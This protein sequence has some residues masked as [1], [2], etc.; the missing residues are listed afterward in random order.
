MA[1]NDKKYIRKTGLGGAGLYKWSPDTSVKKNPNK[2][3]IGGIHSC[4]T[5]IGTQ[6]NDNSVTYTYNVVVV[7]GQPTRTAYVQCDYVE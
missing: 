4:S 5:P 2:N 1:S 6:G 3:N 7:L